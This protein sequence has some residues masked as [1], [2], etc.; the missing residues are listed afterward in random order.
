M[1][2]LELLTDN[3]IV[4]KTLTG[5]TSH[6]IVTYAKAKCI[7]MIILGTHGYNDLTPMIMGSVA[8]NVVRIAACPVLTVRPEKFGFAMPW[9]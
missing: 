8:E 2:A 5:N 1:V 9:L 7:D 6:E 4:H 3:T